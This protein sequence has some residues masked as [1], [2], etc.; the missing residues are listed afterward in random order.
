MIT[1][2]LIIAAAL[3]REPVL[4][5][6]GRLLA[7]D[8]VVAN[9]FLRRLVQFATDFTARHRHLPS[10]GDWEMWLEGLEVGMVRDGTKEALGWLMM[11]NVDGYD[12]DHFVESVQPILLQ[13][14][15]AVA[16]T[17]LNE[18]ATVDPARVGHLAG[19]GELLDQPD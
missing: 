18:S 11:L 5:G 13:G 7:D 10:S 6:L 19:D 15:S 9:P 12:L 17:R 16:K 1:L 2:E 8:L 3:R 14:A 4:R